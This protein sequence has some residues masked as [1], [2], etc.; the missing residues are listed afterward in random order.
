MSA[1]FKRWPQRHVTI[2]YVM[3]DG[4]NDRKKD[5]EDFGSSLKKYQI[6]SKINLIP[7]NPFL[8]QIMFAHL[9]TKC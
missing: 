7:F 3:L 9:P 8:V 6:K 2:E 4:V 5:A 1:L